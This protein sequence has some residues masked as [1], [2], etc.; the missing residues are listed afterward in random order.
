[1]PD[2]YRFSI[3][4]QLL[5]SHLVLGCFVAAGS[6]LL[7]WL[8]FFFAQ[9]YTMDSLLQSA[10]DAH[11]DGPLPAEFAVVR[12]YDEA[13]PLPADVAALVDDSADGVHELSGNTQERHV[14]VDTTED[15]RRV[16]AFLQVPEDDP[17]FFITVAVL[18]GA[19]VS[20]LLALGLAL[21][22]ARR[23]VTPAV[24]LAQVLENKTT[25]GLPEG[26]SASFRRDEIG[27]VARRLDDYVQENEALVARERGF[28]RDAAHELRTP[29]QTLRGVVDVVRAAGPGGAAQWQD[30]IERVSRN[31]SRMEHAVRTLLWLH[32]REQALVTLGRDDFHETLTDAIDELRPGLSAQVQLDC[33]I[34][35]DAV[36]AL[37]RPRAAWIVAILNLVENAITHTATGS[38]RV[39]VDPQRI[40]VADTG[41]GITDDLL[42]RVTEPWVRGDRKEGIG[43]GLSI[44][45]CI[46]SRAGWQLELSSELDQGTTAILSSLEAAVAD[47][48]QRSNQ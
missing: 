19:L 26:F 5:V 6:G 34:G 32:R 48:G 45:D 40:V 12:V 11:A 17:K 29:L 43:L 2:A 41:A 27:L 42:A 36:D 47:S 21:A 44:V 30:K 38:I 13:S 39:S 24:E 1:M 46:A 22:S 31:V 9:D 25:R 14:L 37:P 33:T 10:V 8:F 15:G 16:V 3:L 35:P 20:T 4:R 7:L 28:L 18:S 23:I